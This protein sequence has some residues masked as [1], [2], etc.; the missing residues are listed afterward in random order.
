VIVHRAAAEC[1]RALE[2]RAKASRR[3]MMRTRFQ[4]IVRGIV[5]TH[6]NS[7]FD[8]HRFDDTLELFCDRTVEFWDLDYRA[9]ALRMILSDQV[10]PDQL[11][12]AIREVGHQSAE[13]TRRVILWTHGE[14]EEWKVCFR[15]GRVCFP[16]R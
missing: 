3:V 2:P 1:L 9:S 4:L 14:W 11:A 7:S 5:Q 13:V 12:K 10:P 8:D 16:R 15:S 6:V